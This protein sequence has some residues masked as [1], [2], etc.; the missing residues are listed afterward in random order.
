MDRTNGRTGVFG[1]AGGSLVWMG[2]HAFATRR[3]GDAM[4]LVD[5]NGTPGVPVLVENRVFGMTDNDGFLLLPEAR[6]WQRNRIAI[7]PDVLGY[8]YLVTDVEQF[9]TPADE[10]AVRLRFDIHRL[11]PATLTLLDRAGKPLPAGTPTRIG[12]QEILVAYDGQA[13]VADLAAGASIEA[14]LH[15]YRCR[16]TPRTV[17]GA[18]G[19][20]QDVPLPCE[21]IEG[22]SQ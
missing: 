7:D 10:G 20:V 17:N 15:G 14:E 1:Q 22:V 19:H 16:F 9:A 6:G 11:H 18:D 5:T 13:W 8:E 12:E 4:V 2:R 3:V 21:V